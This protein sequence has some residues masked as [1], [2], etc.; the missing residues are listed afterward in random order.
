MRAPI[1]YVG[2]RVRIVSWSK[3]ANTKLGTVEP[4][5]IPGRVAVLI[6]GEAKFHL[7]FDGEVSRLE[8][9]T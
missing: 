4:N 2:D 1:L 6:D 9:G 5:A 7:F 8:E 3:W